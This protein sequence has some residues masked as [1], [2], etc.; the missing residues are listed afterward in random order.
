MGDNVDTQHTG[1]VLNSLLTTLFNP[2]E[3]MLDL[4]YTLNGSCWPQ[5]QPQQII[6]ERNL[7]PNQKGKKA[8]CLLTLPSLGWNE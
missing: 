3:F 1:L 2:M 5:S 8:P 7:I 4:S 6:K